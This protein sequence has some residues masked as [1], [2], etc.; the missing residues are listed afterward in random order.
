M[1]DGKEVVF[2]HGA[3]YFTVTDP[4]VSALVGGWEARGL[5]AEWKERLGSFDVKSRIFDGLGEVL[6]SQTHL[7]ICFDSDATMEA[8]K[9]KQHFNP[10]L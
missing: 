2:D 6:V 5:V 7:C 9:K 1:G 10:K 8:L 3:P 4:E